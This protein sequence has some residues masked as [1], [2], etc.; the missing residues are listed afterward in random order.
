M[1]SV[2]VVCLAAR[3][4]T[5]LGAM[6]DVDLER[7]QFGCQSGEPLD[8]PLGRSI[9]HHE[10]LALDVTQVAQGLEEGLSKVRGGGR[11]VVVPQQV[12][13]SS[14]LGRRLGRRSERLDEDTGQRGQ[15]EAAAVHAG[16]VSRATNQ[17]KRT[18]RL[19]GEGL[20]RPVQSRAARSSSS[21][22]RAMLAPQSQAIQTAVSR[23]N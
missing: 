13:Y 10:V 17:V 3:A 19:E 16:M 4:A 1:G 5:V 6:N 18:A 23:F 2:L 14:D 7:H 22:R 9:L 8:L 11:S 20:A 21:T 15:Q 12:A